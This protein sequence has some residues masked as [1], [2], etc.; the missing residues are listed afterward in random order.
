MKFVFIIFNFS[1]LFVFLS[2]CNVSLKKET[3]IVKYYDD[4]KMESQVFVVGN[5]KNGKATLFYPNG[6]IKQEGNWK[7]DKQEGVWLFYYED[8]KLSEKIPFKNDLQ[9][10]VSVFYYPDGS[11]SQETDFIKGKANGISKIYYQSI[12]KVKNLSNWSDGKRN[13]EQT[14]FDSVGSGFRK[15]IWKDDAVVKSLQ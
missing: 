4:G 14:I 8:G 6:Q 13:G 11:L 5:K 1:L 3:K 10:G 7:D 2:A 15:Y 9:D 12:N